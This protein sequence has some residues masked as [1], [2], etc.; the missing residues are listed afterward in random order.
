VAI[1]ADRNVRQK[2]N[3]IQD[4]MYRDTNNVDHEMCDYTG[5]DWSHRNSNNSFK[6]KFGSHSKKEI[7]NR[8]TTEDSYT[9]SIT[10]VITREVLQSEK[11]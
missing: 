4:L 6:E 11:T 8:F 10:R 2:E 7:L 5:N 3:K 9:W 1:L